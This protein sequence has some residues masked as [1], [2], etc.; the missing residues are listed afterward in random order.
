MTIYMQE[1]GNNNTSEMKGCCLGVMQII[2]YY[3][4][5]LYGLHSTGSPLNKYFQGL[6]EKQ[7]KK[8]WGP[9]LSVLSCWLI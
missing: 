8:P 2:H 3:I 5:D 1:C 6:R 9:V 4:G 7:V